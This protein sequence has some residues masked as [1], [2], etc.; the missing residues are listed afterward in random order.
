[1]TP[2][3]P[4][5][6]HYSGRIRERVRDLLGRAIQEGVG[7]RVSRSLQY[8]EGRL[9]LH[10]TVWGERIFRYHVLGLDVYQR[11]YDGIYVVFSV[12][13]EQRRVWL[14]RLYPIPGHVLHDPKEPPN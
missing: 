9:L 2:S 10:P 3:G 1:M 11:V 12:S 13:E 14:T 7:P 5:S 4:Y 6:V 8:I